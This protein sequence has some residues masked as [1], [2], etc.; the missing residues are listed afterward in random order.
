[1]KNKLAYFVTKTSLFGITTFLLFET[2]GKNSYLSIILGTILSISII[3]FYTKFKSINKKSIIY[4]II[5][6]LFSI[7]LATTYLTILSSFINTFYLVK[8]PKIIVIISFLMLS[9]Y[10]CFKG[11]DTLINISN[12]LFYFSIILVTTF[13]LLL[14]KYVNISNIY[15][16]FNYNPI[17]IIKSSIIYALITS[18]PLILVIPYYKDNKELYKDY[19]F[20]SL[21][22]LSIIITIILCMGEPLIK[23]YNFP[24]YIVLKQIRYLDFIENIESFSSFAWYIEIFITLSLILMNIK[25]TLPKNNNRLLFILLAILIVILTFIINTNYK[26]I[27]ILYNYYYIIL[28]IFLLIFI[29]FYF[30]RKKL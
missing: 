15:P 27:L 18:V 30:I 14:T 16:I 11:K 20:A 2:N 5:I 22:N 12:L 28:L 4:K 10:L 3:Y 24:E 26:Y 17:N 7:F 19:I 21:T 13:S 8:T 29:I 1:M 25:N 9:I 23:I 6:I